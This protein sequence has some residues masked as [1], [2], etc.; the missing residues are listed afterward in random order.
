MMQS[1]RRWSVSKLR[2]DHRCLPVMPGSGLKKS[3]REGFSLLELVVVIAIIGLVVSKV[4]STGADV[5]RR[6]LLNQAITDLQSWLL[7]VRTSPDK[8][9]ISCTVV[10]NT[11]SNLAGNTAMA[12]VTSSNSS[13]PCASTSSVRLPAA[14]GLTFTVSAQGPTGFSNTVI[15]T[16]RS[17]TTATT[18]VEVGIAISRLTGLRCLRLLPVSGLLRLARNNS[19]STFTSTTNATTLNCTTSNAL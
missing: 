3:G 12:T 6:D 15:F 17:A 18:N 4:A 19:T 9:G 7:E 13:I 10:F 5:Y 11:G 8:N 2:F 14:G 1:L 16:R